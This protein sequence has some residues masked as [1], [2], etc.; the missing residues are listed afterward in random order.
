MAADLESMGIVDVAR[1]LLSPV[2]SVSNEYYCSHLPISVGFLS[3]CQGRE[4]GTLL[5]WFTS[6]AEDT[7]WTKRRIVEY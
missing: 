1:D 4:E 6:T 2:I 5:H 7:G 3:L